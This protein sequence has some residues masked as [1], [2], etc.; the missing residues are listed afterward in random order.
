MR[1]RL[2]G[3]LSPIRTPLNPHLALFFFSEGERSHAGQLQGRHCTPSTFTCHCS[4]NRAR[5]GVAPSV[6]RHVS[7]F[8]ET[9]GESANERPHDTASILVHLRHQARWVDLRKT[10]GTSRDLCSICP[11][12]PS[13]SPPND[14]FPFCMVCRCVLCDVQ[15]DRPR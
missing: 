12:S 3:P 10:D 8:A 11:L 5:S 15:C 6:P 7:H 9:R 13:P 4:P 1:T 2:G 14:R